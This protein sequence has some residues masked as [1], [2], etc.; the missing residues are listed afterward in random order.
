MKLQDIFHHTV[1]GLQRIFIIHC[2][3]RQV[4]HRRGGDR[5]EHFFRDRCVDVCPDVLSS[6]NVVSKLRLSFHT[7]LVGLVIPR[8]KNVP[9]ACCCI[10]G[11]LDDGVV[12][13]PL[14]LHV[15]GDPLVVHWNQE[16]RRIGSPRRGRL[17]G[18]GDTFRGIVFEV[19]R[20][21]WR[22]IFACEGLTGI[23]D[24][25][26][27][28]PRDIERA[29]ADRAV[30]HRVVRVSGGELDEEVNGVLHG[31]FPLV[32]G[33]PGRAL[34]LGLRTH[35]GGPR[36]EDQAVCWVLKLGVQQLGDRPLHRRTISC[37]EEL[38]L[39]AKRLRRE[40]SREVP[41]EILDEQTGHPETALHRLLE[42]LLVRGQERE[43]VH[44]LRLVDVDVEDA[45]EVAVCDVLT[46]HHIAEVLVIVRGQPRPR[47]RTLARPANETTIPHDHQHT[48]LAIGL[49]RDRVARE[50]R[51][52]P[53]RGQVATSNRHGVQ[54]RDARTL[55]LQCV[56]LNVRLGQQEGA[57]LVGAHQKLGV[58]HERRHDLFGLGRLVENLQ[59]ELVGRRLLE[60]VRERLGRL[61]LG[62]H[63]RHVDLEQAIRGAPRATIEDADVA[64]GIHRASTEVATQSLLMPKG[65]T[66]LE[67]RNVE[68]ILLTV[69]LGIPLLPLHLQR[70]PAEASRRAD[71]ENALGS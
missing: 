42:H 6:P 31:R 27:G 59:L 38:G 35:R 41:R 20:K 47:V 34:A 61:G 66:K 43:T 5:P 40:R 63:E 58:A 37:K 29:L 28:I 55:G 71:L 15:N 33:G 13:H 11:T 32:D 19:Q 4:I 18:T 60:D 16:F 21:L 17:E 50:D 53:T 57:L 65:H 69:D 25:S 68:N 52:R 36:C 23:E 14:A 48:A 44:L 54:E 8:A 26:S 3:L 10:P 22:G 24:V 56:P 39:N 70:N 62:L 7:I 2:V 67:I 46:I 1:T 9:A 51:V 49:V 45:E 30:E 12:L 64:L